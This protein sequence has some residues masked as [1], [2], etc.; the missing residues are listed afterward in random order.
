MTFMPLAVAVAVLLVL[1]TRGSL[2]RLGRVPLRALDLLFAGLVLQVV[3][4]LVDLPR[5]RLDDVGFGLLLASY[6]LILTFCLANLHVRGMTIVAVGVALNAVVIALNQGMP[7]NGPT[8][9]GADGSQVSRVVTSVK[10]RPER[11]G[12]LL[13]VLDDR[14]ML[15]RPSHDLLS[16]G[17]LI[18]VAGLLDLCFWGSRRDDDAWASVFAGVGGIHRPDADT[19]KPIRL[20]VWGRMATSA[21]PAAADEQVI[22]LEEAESNAAFLSAGDL[23]IDLRDGIATRMAQLDEDERR[24]TT[25]SSAAST[26][27]SYR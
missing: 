11:S 25:R 26:P 14:I 9:A 5:A 6:A 4:A 20:S 13:R 15:P 27:A 23:V 17:D 18:L 24:A 16:F 8:R 22:D 12:D 1:L 7:A 3:L 21:P 2:L 10:H 19:V